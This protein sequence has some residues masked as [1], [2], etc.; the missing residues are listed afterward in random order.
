MYT[1][2]CLCGGIKFNIHQDIDKIF[3]CHCKQCQKAQGSA[4]VAIAVI[5]TKNIAFIQG[6]HLIA[7]YSTVPEKKRVFC[8]NCAS[9]LYSAREDLP[10]VVRLRVGVINEDLNAK[11]FSHAFTSYKA[12][13]FDI[14]KDDSHIFLEKVDLQC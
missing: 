3:I 7:A 10:K 9:P 13:W 6:E 14:A 1:A 5:E 12:V 8:K 11:V 2:S 4:F